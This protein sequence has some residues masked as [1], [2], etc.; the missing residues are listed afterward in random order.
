MPRNSKLESAVINADSH[1]SQA[2][3]ERYTMMSLLLGA[4]LLC[5]IDR[6]IISLAVIEMQREF[7]WS[8]SEK[9]YVLSVFSAGYLVTQLLGGLLSNRFGGRN[10]YLAAVFAWSLVTVLTPASAYVAFGALITLRILLGVGE[11]SA[12]PAAYNLIHGW[13]PLVERSRAIA[14]VSTA[15]ALGT[16][17]ALLVTGKLIEWYGWQFVF[18]LF[19]SMGFAWCLAWAFAVPSESPLYEPTGT[20]ASAR[21]FFLRIPWKTLLTHPAIVALYVVNFGGQ[22]ITFLM[23]AWLPS[24]LVDT[25]GTSITG[26]GIYSIL[27]WVTLSLVTFLAGAYAD[28]CIAAGEP[29]LPLRKRLVS[30]GFVLAVVSLAGITQVPG[31]YLATGLVMVI[32]AGVGIIIPGIS[33]IPAELLPRHGDILFGFITASGAVGSIVFVSAT[34][35]LLE[36]TGSYDAIF[37]CLA[38]ACAISLLTFR[39]FART[40]EIEL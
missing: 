30:T 35:I 27:P 22:A 14:L 17:G 15:A 7:G 13:M 38:A 20:R 8:D 24:Y 28:R 11:G 25:F 2:W 34:G 37:L 10:V 31:L 4:L 29:S 32:F 3:P 23:A 19:G 1:G 6:T 26:A 16:V 40:D 18:Y 33:T 9:G 12:Y 36:A 39:T 5:Y 21:E